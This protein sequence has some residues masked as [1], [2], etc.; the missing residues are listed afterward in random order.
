MLLQHLLV[1]N[2]CI[3]IENIQLKLILVR[4]ERE[5]NNIMN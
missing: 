4:N 1:G 3:S 2:D 5:D